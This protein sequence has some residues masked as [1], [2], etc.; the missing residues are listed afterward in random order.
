[1]TSAFLLGLAIG[2]LPPFILLCVDVRV[3]REWRHP[4]AVIA[5]YRSSIISWMERNDMVCVHTSRVRPRDKA[6]AV[7]FEDGSRREL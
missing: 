2:F 6:V 4:R 7:V 5:E 1:M 3:T